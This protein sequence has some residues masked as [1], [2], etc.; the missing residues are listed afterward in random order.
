MSR[1]RVSLLYKPNRVAAV[2]RAL[3][4]RG[5]R[6]R[7]RAGRGYYYFDG[8]GLAWQ[9][10]SVYVNRAAELSVAEWL[11]E[12]EALKLKGGN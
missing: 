9:S 12:F 10:S 6:A 2:N 1:R 7:L 8:D 11:A 5:E 4:L 3:K